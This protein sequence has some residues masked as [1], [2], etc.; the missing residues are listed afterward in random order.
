[1]WEIALHCGPYYS[2]LLSGILWKLIFWSGSDILYLHIFLIKVSSLKKKK[3][4]KMK[5]SDPGLYELVLVLG[6]TAA[7]SNSS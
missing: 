7:F 3:K 5:L 6:I 2:T 4:K 1:M